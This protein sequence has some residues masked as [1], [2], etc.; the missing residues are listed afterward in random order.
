MPSILGNTS[1]YAA[2]LR[3]V[4]KMTAT[5]R[6]QNKHPSWQL[7]NKHPSSNHPHHTPY[8]HLGTLQMQKQSCRKRGRQG[9]HT[10]GKSDQTLSTVDRR[11]AWHS[12]QYD[13]AAH[14]LWPH[15]MQTQ[16]TFS[17]LPVASTLEL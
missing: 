9:V 13:G 14:N 17:D 3:Y 16:H 15:G 4:A 11:N 5:C 6:L 2:H 1:E 12:D 10:R 7:Q 8:T